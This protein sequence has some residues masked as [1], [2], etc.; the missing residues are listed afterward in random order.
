MKI[1]KIKWDSK[2]DDNGRMFGTVGNNVVGV[3]VVHRIIY[4][5][6]TTMK[7]F[8]FK[9]RLVILDELTI[10]EFDYDS[11]VY[12]GKETNCVSNEIMLDMTLRP[13]YYSI[14]EIIFL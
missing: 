10:V 9:S 2:R 1:K 13:D 4:R 6:V 12:I 8:N 7:D 5:E 14:R 11:S 3:V